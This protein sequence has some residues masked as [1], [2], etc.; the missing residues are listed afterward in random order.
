MRPMQRGNVVKSKD[1]F[2]KEEYLIYT[3]E[4][5]GM[6]YLTNCYETALNISKELL[7]TV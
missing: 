6:Y 3:D 5:L 7:E 4:S 1:I 2:G